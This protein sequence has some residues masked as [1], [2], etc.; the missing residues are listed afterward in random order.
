MDDG[1]IELLRE[2]CEP[3]G[4][5]AFKRMFGG[6]GLMAEGRMFAL[7]AGDVLHFKVDDESAGFYE[8][9]GLE[10]FAYTT[11]GGRRTVMSYA[12]APE[13]VFDDPDAFAERAQAAIAAARRTALAA[14]EPRRRARRP[15]FPV[16]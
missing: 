11:K 3:L 15:A 10:R 4:P 9:R 13:E 16:E 14:A 5:V 12:R 2:F 1:T 7:V 6:W 8:A